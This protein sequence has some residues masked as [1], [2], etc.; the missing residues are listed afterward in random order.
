[1]MMN[2]C[3]VPESRDQFGA[4][5][6]AVQQQQGRDED[7]SPESETG[8]DRRETQAEAARSVWRKRHQM[9]PKL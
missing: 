4:G 7:G 1:M 8:T 2:L 9:L 3:S 6:A 5:Q